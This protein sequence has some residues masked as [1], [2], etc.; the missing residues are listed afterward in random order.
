MGE[1]GRGREEPDNDEPTAR[2]RK[3]QQ[4]QERFLRNS[5]FWRRDEPMNGWLVIP[6]AG[7]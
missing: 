6:A 2:I 3:S 4:L 5:S 7:A 1:I